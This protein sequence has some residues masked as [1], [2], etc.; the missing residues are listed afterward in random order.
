MQAHMLDHIGQAVI[1]TDTAGRVTY[2]NLFAGELYGWGRTDMLGRPITEVTV[3]QT[4]KEEAAE[5]LAHLRAGENW[6]GELMVQDRKGRVFP[7]H[8]TDSPVIDDAGQLRREFTPLF[9]YGPR[10]RHCDRCGGSEPHAGEE[11]AQIQKGC[12]CGRL[13]AGGCRRDT[14]AHAGKE[15]AEEQESRCGRRGHECA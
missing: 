10:D 15:G 2:A 11:N 13:H 4:T 5:I 12:R 9:E 14:H 3:A 8:V 7:A 6:S 1:A